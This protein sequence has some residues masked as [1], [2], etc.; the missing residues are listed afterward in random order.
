M[1]KVDST[2]VAPGARVFLAQDKS[3]VKLVKTK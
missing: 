2:T 3:P 1:M